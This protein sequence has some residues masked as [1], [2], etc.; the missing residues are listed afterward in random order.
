[1][2]P[3]RRHG[4]RRHGGP[5]RRADVAIAGDRIAAIGEVSKAAGAR[6]IDVAASSSRPASSTCIP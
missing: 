5:R 1:L 4:D 3:A 6:E 2:D